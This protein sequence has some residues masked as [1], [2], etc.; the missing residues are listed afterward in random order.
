MG[1][2][3]HPSTPVLNDSN[4]SGAD[5]TVMPSF[6]PDLRTRNDSVK[7]RITMGEVIIWERECLRTEVSICDGRFRVPPV[8]LDST[9]K[10]TVASTPELLELILARLPIT[11]RCAAAR[12]K[13]WQTITLSPTLQHALFFRADPSSDSEAIR[14]PSLVGMFPLF[15]APPG[16]SLQFG[17]GHTF[18][19]RFGPQIQ[20]GLE[21]WNTRYPTIPSTE[22]SVLPVS[23]CISRLLAFFPAVRV[24]EDNLCDLFVLEEEGILALYILAP[25]EKRSR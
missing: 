9:A 18:M 20:F 16:W 11:G 5:Q 25:S 14:N 6:P 22:I 1:G 17:N 4:Q 13:T 7:I 10:A 15:F 8:R 2:G 23:R 24:Y 3:E 19:R 21:R 12:C